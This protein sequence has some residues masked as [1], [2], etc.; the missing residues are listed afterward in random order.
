MAL[1]RSDL[2]PEGLPEHKN[3]RLQNGPGVARP[4]GISRPLAA[5]PCLILADAY[6]R[7]LERTPLIIVDEVGHLP[8]DAEAANLPALGRRH[9]CSSSSSPPAT[10]EPP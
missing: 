6:L 7:Q 5:L 2:P 1:R 3:R 10:N 9:T 4:G 8:F